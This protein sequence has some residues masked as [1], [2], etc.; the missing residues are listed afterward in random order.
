MAVPLRVCFAASEVAPLAKTGGLADVAGALP[1]ELFLR[2]LDVR[3]FTP[4]HAQVDGTA[5]R[6]RPEPCEEIVLRLGDDRFS[7]ALWRGDLPGSDLPVYL[8]D[9][10]PLF[11][12]ESVYTAGDDE[13]QRF[14]VF[15]HGVVE[16]CQRLGWAPGIF[17]CHD[18]HTGLVPLLLKSSYAWDAIFHAS[19]SILTIH[20]IG[21]QGIFP[22]TELADLGLSGAAHLLDPAELERGN[23]GFLRSG[24]ALADAVTTV[25]PTYAKE[26]RTKEY[27]MGLEEALAARPDGV[28]GILNGVDY[29]EWSPERDRWIP[30]RYSRSRPEGKQKNK[31]YLLD[32]LALRGEPG[33][34]LLGIVSRLAYQKGFELC[35]SV[36]PDLL[37]ENDLRLVV[38]GEGERDYVVFFQKLASRYPDR[39]HFHRGHSEELAHLIEAGADMF[40]MPSRYEPC[41]LNQMFSLRYGTIP[42]VRRTGGLADTVEP[43]DADRGTGTGFVFDPFTP[44]ALRRALDDALAAY[45]DPSLWNRLMENGMSQDYSW[46]ARARDYEELYRRLG[47]IPEK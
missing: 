39:V 12:R 38:L 31:R 1:R 43:F 25:S 10:P 27:G 45:G 28:T 3:V 37:A 23:I 33:P 36:L 6:A 19:R 20:N 5:C 21:Y 22:S 44:R 18:W 8:L 9:C 26:I 29:E 11:H 14:S 35:F 32:S 46:A 42:V 15:S 47:S 40:L 4:F 34:P 41:G 24:V 7:I 16:A 2:G 13:G 30:H 17:H